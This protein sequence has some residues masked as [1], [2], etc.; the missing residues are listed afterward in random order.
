MLKEDGKTAQSQKWMW[1]T[2]GGTPDKPSVLF[3]YDAGPVRWP[4]DYSMGSP[5]HCRLMATR[6]MPPCVR[7]RVSGAL[8]AGIMRGASSEASRAGP[9]GKGKGKAKGKVAKA[10]VALSHIRAAIERK[11]AEQP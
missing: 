11:I 6:A 3:A 7:S 8:G 10:D 4:S 9:T 2:R 5:A 1:V